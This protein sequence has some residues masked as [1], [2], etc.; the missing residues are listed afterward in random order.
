M[1]AFQ[2]KTKEEF[3]SLDKDKRCYYLARLYINRDKGDNHLPYKNR[4]FSCLNYLK[5]QPEPLLSVLYNYLTDN[6]HNG[7]MIWNI[8]PKAVLYDEKR[9][10]KPIET[11][12][13]EYKTFDVD[14]LNDILNELEDS[15]ASKNSSPKNNII[16]ESN[17][18]EVS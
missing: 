3:V 17:S 18:K 12:T 10:R 5:K 2:Y 14:M 7:L 6:T 13:Q 15:D 11:K 4:L 9:R 16:H 8:V 1:M